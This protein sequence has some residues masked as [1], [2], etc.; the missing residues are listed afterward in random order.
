M[1]VSEKIESHKDAV[2][3]EILRSGYLPPRGHLPLLQE[4]A[5]RVVGEVVAKLPS[6]DQCDLWEAVHTLLAGTA[7]LRD[8]GPSVPDQ[9][10][11][12]TWSVRMAI[13]EGAKTVEEASTITGLPVY[14][15]S[16]AWDYVRSR[17][18]APRSPREADPPW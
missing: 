16:F 1:T 17:P 4:A 7:E 2:L 12:H 5:W 10:P 8:I 3:R 18:D 13:R 6:R 11:R 14:A 9:P 15:I